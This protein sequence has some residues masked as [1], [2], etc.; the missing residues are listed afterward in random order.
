MKK[1]ALLLFTAA[2]L[3]GSTLQASFTEPVT[4]SNENASIAKE[5]ILDD[6]VAMDAMKEFKSLSRVDRK[7]RMIEAKKLLKE[8]KVQKAVNAEPSTNTILLAILAIL[9]PP[10]AVYL[11]EGVINGKFWLS[12]LLTLCF[13]IPGVIYALIVVLG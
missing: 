3:T 2:I 13:W 7:M 11:H 1:I 6:V 5:I 12:I 9:L 4:K 10:L 8:Y